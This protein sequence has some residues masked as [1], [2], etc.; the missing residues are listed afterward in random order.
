MDF[1]KFLKL[2]YR[3]RVLL[4]C[5]PIATVIITYF[6]V[7][8]LPNQYTS[9]SRI[10]TGIV[11]QSQNV[12]NQNDEQESKISQEFSNLTQMMLLNK[13]V[14]QVSYKLIIHDLTDKKPFKPESKLLQTLSKEKRA[15]VLKVYG[16]H[17]KD[18]T[19]LSLFDGDEKGMYEVLKSMGY[20]DGSLRKKLAVYRVNNSDFIDV[21]GV[22]ED[23]ELAA[24][25]VNTLCTEFITY[26]TSIVKE[27]QLKAVNF[28][29]KLLKEKQDIMN[30]A[31][32]D[33]KNYKIKNHVLNLNEQAKSLY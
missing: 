25:I 11:D 6:L 32:L 29:E 16:Q 9:H 31:M 22:A 33:L 10:A 28:Y 15:L 8:E 20:D 27:N 30:K 21:E 7:R 19:E 2:L 4:V 23:P 24:F 3:R 26:Y 5:I 17:Y 1:I 14:D 13:I 12:F 18:R